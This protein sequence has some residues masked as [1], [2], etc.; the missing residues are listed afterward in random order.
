MPSGKS[1]L[2]LSLSPF[3][4]VR[5]D[6][7]FYFFISLSLFGKDSFAQVF[8]AHRFF[9][10]PNCCATPI[11]ATMSPIVPLQYSWLCPLV[12]IIASL[13]YSLLPN[14]KPPSCPTDCPTPY[15]PSYPTPCPTNFSTHRTTN[16]QTDYPTPSPTHFP[17]KVTISRPI[18]RL[19][20]LL[21]VLP[22]F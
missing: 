15:P 4:Q 7:P 19:T 6:L 9:H 5:A 8:L 11:S 20:I 3:F 2:G 13:Q 21:L 18:F 14:Y 22:T 10:P 17:T 16:F 1:A 12:S